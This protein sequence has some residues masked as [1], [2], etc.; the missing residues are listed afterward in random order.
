MAKAAHGAAFEA[1]AT[2]HD[3]A[4]ALCAIANSAPSSFAFRSGGTD[5]AAEDRARLLVDR[6]AAHVYP[7]VDPRVVDCQLLDSRWFVVSVSATYDGDCGPRRTASGCGYRVREGVLEACSGDDVSAARK[8]YFRQWKEHIRDARLIVAGLYLRNTERRPRRAFVAGSGVAVTAAV[9]GLDELYAYLALPFDGSWIIV[10]RV[11]A[12]KWIEAAGFVSTS[13]PPQ[14]TNGHEAYALT[15]SKGVRFTRTME[16]TGRVSL[17]AHRLSFRERDGVVDPRSIEMEDLGV[18]ADSDGTAEVTQL[19]DIAA[20]IAAATAE[21]QAACAA[22][23]GVSADIA[24]FRNT[25]E[26]CFRRPPGAIRALR[27][28]RDE[29]CPLEA[30]VEG[31]QLPWR[32]GPRVEFKAKINIAADVTPETKTQ[33]TTERLRQIIAAMANTHGGAVLVGVSDDGT[34][35]GAPKILSHVRLTQFAPAF[36]SDAIACRELPVATSSKAAAPTMAADWWKAPPKPPTTAA[37]G[38]APA[39]D[40]QKVVTVIRVIMGTAPFH[41]TGGTVDSAPMARGAASTVAL[42]ALTMV[43]RIVADRAR[44][45]EAK[46]ARDEDFE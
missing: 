5:R 23:E 34:V 14:V 37:K 30:V 38:S 21:V 29:T 46:R 36:P 6:A 12:P 18:E 1:G 39:D 13:P 11:A 44:R 4:A 40:Q 9:C 15:H 32:E 45:E 33:T 41:L 16:E 22:N 26:D 17:L 2:I 31:Q 43:E 28:V 42:S 7:Q 35:L 3:V 20:S 24:R 27:K 10:G 19:A 8:A 25:G